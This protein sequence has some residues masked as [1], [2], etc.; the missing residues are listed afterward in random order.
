[1][2]WAERRWLNFPPGEGARM[3]G[4]EA[5]CYPAKVTRGHRLREHPVCFVCAWWTGLILCG[6]QVMGLFLLRVR[7]LIPPD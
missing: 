1:M 5:W 4:E 7:Q 2:M 6:A 3:A